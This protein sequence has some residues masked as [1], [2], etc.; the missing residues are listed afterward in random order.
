MSCSLGH[1]VEILWGFE[2]PNWGNNL[3]F[4]KS[5]GAFGDL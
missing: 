4:F 1:K 2:W 5:F 3:G